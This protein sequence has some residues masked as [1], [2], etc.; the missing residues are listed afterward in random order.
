MRRVVGSVLLALLA[1]GGFAQA[2]DPVKHGA[3]TLGALV[4]VLCALVAATFDRDHPPDRLSSTT[5]RVSK[6]LPENP[7]G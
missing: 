5:T 2:P 1:A 7:S 3:V 6:H 4:L